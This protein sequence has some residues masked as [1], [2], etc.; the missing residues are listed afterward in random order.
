MSYNYLKTFNKQITQFQR[1]ELAKIIDAKIKRGE[2]NAASFDSELTD[3][4]AKIDPNN[5]PI[6]KLRLVESS[7]DSPTKISSRDYNDLITEAHVDLT[8]LFN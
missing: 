4:M 1:T 8:T 3:A 7:V 2:L 5:K 6:I